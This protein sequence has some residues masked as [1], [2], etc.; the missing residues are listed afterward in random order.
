MVLL[1]ELQ[2]KLGT[3]HAKG[4]R[5]WPEKEKGLKRAVKVEKVIE[6]DAQEI[7][8]EVKNLGK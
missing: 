1:P 8:E 4:A 6:Q 2:K 7:E 3:V 5:V